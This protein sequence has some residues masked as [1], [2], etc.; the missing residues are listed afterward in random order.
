MGMVR[1]E[2]VPD[3]QFQRGLVIEDLFGDGPG[4]LSHWVDDYLAFDSLGAVK[5]AVG[6]R[7]TAASF[8]KFAGSVPF[9]TITVEF[10]RCIALDD[11]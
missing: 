3:G 4:S 2:H 6:Y 1:V 7:T 8:L 5:T 10:L 11:H 9:K